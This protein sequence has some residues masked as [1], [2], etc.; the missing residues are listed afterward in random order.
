MVRMAWA[1]LSRG[2]VQ[3]VYVLR[4]NNYGIDFRAYTRCC[5][6]RGGAVDD[7]VPYNRT[8]I[9]VQSCNGHYW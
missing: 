6:I 3:V 8:Y 4:L 7:V 1:I 9:A 2:I 5:S